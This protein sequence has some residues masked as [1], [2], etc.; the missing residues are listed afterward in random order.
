MASPEHPFP[1]A[2]PSRHPL[3]SGFQLTPD[4][5]STTL[6]VTP[7][8]PPTVASGDVITS[9]HENLTVAALGDLWTNEQ[10]LAAQS[11]S[12]PTSAKGD[13][14]ARD[15]SALAR[16]AVGTAGQVLT[17]DAAAPLG[18]KWAAPAGAVA[19]VFG[20]TG[21]VVAVAGDYTAALVTNAVS[22]LGSYADPGWITSLA[23]AKITG[24]PAA[25]VPTSRQ[26]IAGTGLAGGG[27][28]T[29][30]VTLTAPVMGPSGASHKAGLVPDPGATVGAAR[31]LREDATWG[32]PS[33]AGGGLTDPTTTLG[34]LIVRGAAAP[35]RLGV[36][37]DGQA[38]L[39]D[40]AAP[41]GVKWGAVA[42]GGGSQTPWTSDIN[43]ANFNLNRVKG[44]GIGNLQDAAA[45]FGVFISHDSIFDAFKQINSSSNGWAGF[46]LQNDLGHLFAFRVY[47][48]GRTPSD[49]AALESSIPMTFFTGAVERMRI[50]TAGDVGIGRPPGVKLDVEGYV[51]GQ[52]YVICAG[53]GVD[54][55][56]DC[57]T[58]V[59]AMGTNTAHPL[60][61]ITSAATRMYITAGGDIGAGTTAP[62]RKFQV[63]GFPLGGGM[64]ITGGGP[65]FQMAP[66]DTEPNA[67]VMGA[68][69]TLSTAAGHYGL[70]A[71]DVMLGS[72]GTA[73]G[74]FYINANYSGGG[75]GKSVILQPGG[76][77]VGIG[78]TSLSYQ[79]H[80][81]ADSAA[82]LTTTTWT[83]TSDAR[84]K[85]NI[86]EL[87]GGLEVI[88]RLRPIEAEFNGLG[89][90]PDGH[91]VVG[92]LAN[93][94]RE[95][96]P[97][98][99]GSRRGRLSARDKDETDIL[100]FNM[101]EV[102][103]HLVLAVKQL[104]LKES[105]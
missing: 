82:K 15:A 74:H 71:G 73:R 57:A 10:W 9:L 101:H 63:A 6:P 54:L 38:L 79:L 41:L 39:A 44:I 68:V 69:W 7:V 94:V 56:L 25:G 103:M 27:A 59:G 70:Q 3:P 66:L 98:T 1:N 35:T 64:C 75:T 34:D 100:D 97:G 60:A 86:R 40:S 46:S 72:Q 21:V 22:T 105:N 91:R 87:C 104:A 42:A 11:L 85:K 30:D 50:T 12:D 23:Y 24:A 55:R 26:V 81:S 37:T 17:V 88:K 19:S 77:N 51:R 62:V 52:T 28:L 90:T 31:Y 102:L 89:D 18:V 99:V 5:R 67:Q 83:V 96:L 36:G 84:T 4:V 93:E 13:L 32:I 16:L 80:L 29:A 78:T 20:R 92:F 33:G 61:M 76:G 53:N 43:A 95:V 65:I 45:N 47:G 2:I 48:S 8:I 14:L 58:A 49:V